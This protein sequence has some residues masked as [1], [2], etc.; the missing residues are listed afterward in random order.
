MSV[1]RGDAATAKFS[2]RIFIMGG[3]NGQYLNSVE[4]FDI[5]RNRWSSMAP[6]ICEREAAQ[7]GVANGYLYVV[8]GYDYAGKF[9]SIE[10]Y[11]PKKNTWILVRACFIIL[12][13]FQFICI[14]L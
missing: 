12:Y 3:F 5:T 13:L 6:M 8:G 4:A 10:R 14:E 1:A 11:D 9:S 7:A 2:G